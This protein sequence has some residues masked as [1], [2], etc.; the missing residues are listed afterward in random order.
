MR[1]LRLTHWEIHRMSEDTIR[2]IEA[3]VTER[4]PS[5]DDASG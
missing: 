4:R 5:R 1:L 3:I 2:R